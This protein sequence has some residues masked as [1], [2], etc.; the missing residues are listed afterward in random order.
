M[1]GNMFHKLGAIVT[2]SDARKEHL[3]VVNK[4][5]PHIKTLHIDCDDFKVDE[6][7]NIILHWGLLYYLKEIEIHL[8]NI[9]QKCDIFILLLETEVCDSH[10]KNFYIS[11]DEA[12]YDQAFN[13]RGIRPSQSYVEDVL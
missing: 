2:S 13:N 6:K 1:C 12:G 7:Y 10:D 9:S 5:Y 8:K 3:E 4:K 11:T